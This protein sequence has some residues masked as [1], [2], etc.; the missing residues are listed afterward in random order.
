MWDTLG[1]IFQASEYLQIPT[2]PSTPTH[3]ATFP[4]A[5]FTFDSFF[6]QQK[7]NLEIKKLQSNKLKAYHFSPNSKYSEKLIEISI[8]LYILEIIYFFVKSNFF[9]YTHSPF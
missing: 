6:V 8:K 4:Y 3:L 1:Q 9:A 2:A 7:S 5:L